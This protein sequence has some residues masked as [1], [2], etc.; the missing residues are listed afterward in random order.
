M[1]ESP[2]NNAELEFH[3]QRKAFVLLNDGILAACDGFCGSHFDL[4]CQSGFKPEQARFLISEQPR[5][6]ALNGNVYLYQGADFS[7]LTEENRLK[8]EKWVLFF[9]K[10]GWLNHRGQI[11]DGM[12]AGEAGNVWQPLKEFEI[13]F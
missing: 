9:Q 3:R 4:L 10:N 12:R 5:G 13:S 1:P 6:Y 11:Y 7:C 2:K 8:A